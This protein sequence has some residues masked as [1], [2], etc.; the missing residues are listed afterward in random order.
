[1]KNSIPI[2]HH[3]RSIR[4]KGYDYSLPGAY[5]V[6]LVTYE[7]AC[8]FGEVYKGEVRLNSIGKLAQAELRR[9][10]TQFRHIAI[11]SRVIMPNHIHAIIMINSVGATHPCQNGTLISDQIAPDQFPD[12]NNGSP[13]Q[14]TR[15]SGPAP[16][17]L[18]AVIGQFKSRL[19]KHIW[20]RTGIDHQPIWQRNYYEHIIRDQAEF[21]KIHLYIIE[22]PRKW[23]D[24]QE[25]PDMKP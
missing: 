18:G 11:Q 1:M 2:I 14:K 19:T 7:R 16:K 13:L 25:N 15:P 17:S 8:L 3:R 6:T 4:L 24:D 9:L 10:P 23:S 21:E 20:S 5:F 22:N 12:G